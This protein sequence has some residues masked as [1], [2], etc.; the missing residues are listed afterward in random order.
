M[1]ASS[2]KQTSGQN[3][4]KGGT[5]LSRYDRSGADDVQVDLAAETA[6]RIWNGVSFTDTLRNI[7]NIRG[8]RTGMMSCLGTKV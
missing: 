7:E 6:T 8:S 4:A 3:V 5:D 2:A 1:S